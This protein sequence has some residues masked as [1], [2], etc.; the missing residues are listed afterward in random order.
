MAIK[1]TVEEIINEIEKEGAVKL[2]DIVKGE[3]REKI[4]FEVLKDGKYKIDERPLIN[5]AFV[6]RKNPEYE[7]NES[8]RITSKAVKENIN[9]QKLTNIITTTASV[10]S[11]IFIAITTVQGCNQSTDKQ[12]QNLTQEILELKKLHQVQGKA[13][14]EIKSA[15]DSAAS[16]FKIKL[17]LPQ[18]SGRI[19]K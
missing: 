13:L 4:I 12:L 1:T 18:G 8:V 9:S 5:D 10:L 15:I 17:V 11:V 16:S 14:Y 2:N 6:I 19:K 7:V 3:N